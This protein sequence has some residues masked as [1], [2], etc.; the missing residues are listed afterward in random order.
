MVSDQLQHAI[1]IL[2]S[3]T[4]AIKAFD[5]LRSIDFPM[6]KV[7]IIT[8]KTELDE[9]SRDADTSESTITASEGAKMGA[10]TGATV[11]SSLTLVA[12]LG[13]LL[14]P[15]FGPVLA[16]ES[17]LVTLLGSGVSGTAGGLIGALRGWFFPEE[18]A[19]LYNNQVSQGN[20]LITIEGTK[21]DISCAEQV[22]SR[23]G[24]KDWRVVD[25]PSS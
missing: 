12:G 3:R 16:L 11:G 5:E 13:V 19:Q 14:I 21:D 17:V 23:Y 25:I 7:S 9:Q 8:K 4:I 18:V 24:I 2:P 20:Y 22:L 10:I 6:N 1:G 15:G